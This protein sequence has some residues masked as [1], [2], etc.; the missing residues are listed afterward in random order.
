L[1]SENKNKQ[2]TKLK[3]QIMIEELCAS[4]IQEL[5]SQ[6]AKRIIDHHLGEYV[7]EEGEI[8]DDEWSLEEMQLIAKRIVMGGNAR[9]KEPIV[10]TYDEVY[11]PGSEPRSI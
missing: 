2:N 9:T 4:V 8:I 10:T 6:Y 11:G 7:L 3:M 1:F 5:A